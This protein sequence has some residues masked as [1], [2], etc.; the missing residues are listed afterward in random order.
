MS[1]KA[2]RLAV[3]VVN[4]RGERLLSDLEGSVGKLVSSIRV[5][6]PTSALLATATCLPVHCTRAAR[7]ELHL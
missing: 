1:A 3:P 2:R 6:V 4:G 7:M 5:S